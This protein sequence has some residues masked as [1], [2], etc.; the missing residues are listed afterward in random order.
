[1]LEEQRRGRTRRH[2]GH[3]H[4]KSVKERIRDGKFG[5]SRNPANSRE[6]I[7]GALGVHNV[8]SANAA[9]RGVTSR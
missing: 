3:E 5:V 9:E 7:G 2:E 6:R 8:D 4:C 1:M